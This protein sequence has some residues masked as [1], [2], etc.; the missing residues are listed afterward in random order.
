M[1]ISVRE[2]D[3]STAAIQPNFGSASSLAHT[4]PP[5]AGRGWP[6]ADVAHRDWMSGSDVEARRSE[7]VDRVRQL[8]RR[9]QEASAGSAEGVWTDAGLS[10]LSVETYFIT[11]TVK[12]HFDP[13]KSLPDLDEAHEGSRAT[14][15]RPALSVFGAD[16]SAFPLKTV[17][18][19]V[20]AGDGY[21]DLC[22]VL[23]DLKGA[24]DEALE[25]GFPVPSD[26]ALR[27]ARRLLC[28]MYWILPRRFEVYPTP[29]G[30]IAIDVPGGPGHS[31]LLLCGSDGG[32]L[33]SV[34]MDGAHRRARYSDVRRLPD[35][36]VRDAL[37]EL[38]QSG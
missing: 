19:T 37:I 34:N 15:W 29:D 38:G 6:I 20:L 5:T 16:S 26:A 11:P 18:F 3:A 7:V 28:D 30:E 31:V 4:L 35:G 21:P 2:A 24:R 12:L 32:A 8:S 33:C 36:F 1:T 14:L 22:D 17:D 25:E 10:A 9:L 27:N 13:W 23:R